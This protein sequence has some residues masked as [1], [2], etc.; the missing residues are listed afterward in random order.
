MFAGGNVKVRA[1]LVRLAVVPSDASAGVHF[2]AVL[3]SSGLNQGTAHR[4]EDK[5]A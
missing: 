2:R 5:E 3:I 4:N 1:M